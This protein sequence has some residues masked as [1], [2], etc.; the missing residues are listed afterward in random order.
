MCVKWA[1]AVGTLSA[2]ATTTNSGVSAH[3]THP[4]IQEPLHLAVSIAL[5]ADSTPRD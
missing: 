5:A 1:T 3:Y 2:A 4:D